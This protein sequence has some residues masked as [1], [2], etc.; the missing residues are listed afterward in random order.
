MGESP[1]SFPEGSVIRS[2][3]AV[4]GRKLC[5]LLDQAAGLAGRYLAFVRRETGA[6]ELGEVA[7]L[8]EGVEGGLLIRIQNGG[9]GKRLQEFRGGLLRSGK[10]EPEVK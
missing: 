5:G 10:T 7:T 9:D 4:A 6:G 8:K 2:L 1:A 3:R